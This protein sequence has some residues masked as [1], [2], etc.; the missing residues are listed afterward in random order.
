[1]PRPLILRKGILRLACCPRP[2]ERFSFA[3]ALL[4][5]SICL[6]CCPRTGVRRVGVRVGAARVGV[7]RVGV[8]EGVLLLY[9]L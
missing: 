3:C 6:D 7:R 2:D 8:L 4:K 1:M 9:L 5:A